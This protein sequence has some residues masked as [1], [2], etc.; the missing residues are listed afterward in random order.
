MDWMRF[1]VL[2]KIWRA[3]TDAT[4]AVTRTA[5][6]PPAPNISSNTSGK[7][8]PRVRTFGWIRWRL[9]PIKYKVGALRREKELI[10]LIY[11]ATNEGGI[12]LTLPA[13][14]SVVRSGF[15]ILPFV[16]RS[17]AM[18]VTAT[19]L[20]MVCGC[21]RPKLMPAMYMVV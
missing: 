5:A 20:S 4:H 19:M 16:T 21:V 14:F 2:P 17:C 11:F 3:A 12:G 9:S 15:S 1:I 18:V 8:R 10:A 6:L 7:S 13:E